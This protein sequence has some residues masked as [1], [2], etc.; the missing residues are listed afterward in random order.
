MKSKTSFGRCARFAR[1]LCCCT[2]NHVW[3]EPLKE[4]SRKQKEEEEWMKEA[5]LWVE[6]A[7]RFWHL[8]VILAKNWNCFLFSFCCFYFHESEIVK[9]IFRQWKCFRGKNRKNVKASELSFKLFTSQ[10]LHFITPLKSP[11]TRTKLY[12]M[13]WQTRGLESR[14]LISWIRSNFFFVFGRLRWDKPLR[15]SNQTWIRKNVF[16]FKRKF[17]HRCFSQVSS[18]SRF[19]HWKQN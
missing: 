17:T 4:W 6:I 13:K 16:V 7:S 8:S 18:V 19:F 10:R 5:H 15:K 14:F 2:C 12:I 11:S 3:L 9:D 1:N